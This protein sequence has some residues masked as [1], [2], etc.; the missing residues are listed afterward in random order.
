MEYVQLTLEDYTQSKEEIKKELGGIVKSFVRIGWQL[1]RINKTQAY[2]MDGYKSVTEMAKA[3]YGMTPDG[4]S[5]F[6]NVYEK[7]SVPGDTPQLQ[8][9]YRDYKFS[10]LTEMLKLSDDDQKL[11]QPETQRENIRELKRFNQE[12]EHNPEQLTSWKTETPDKLR[13]TIEEFFRQDKDLTN[14][15]FASEAYHTGNITAMVDMINPSGNRSFRKGTIFLMMYGEEKG[16]MVKDY[17][18]GTST[19]AWSEFAAITRDI[20]SESMD[21]SRIWQKHFDGGEDTENETEKKETEVKKPETET[22]KRTESEQQNTKDSDRKVEKC[23][24]KSAECDRE[25][26]KQREELPNITEQPEDAEKP[27]DEKIQIAPAQHQEQLTGQM[28]VEDYPEL[29][30]EPEQGEVVKKPFGTRKE[31]LDSISVY[32]MSL[33]MAASMEDCTIEEL[34]NQEFWEKWLSEKVNDRGEELK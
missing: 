4:V 18:K 19:I 15:L 7:Y 5:R 8:E 22:Q 20:F 2:Q 13:E 27:E 21:G 32:R 9:C 28:K 3:E 11:I 30:P 24:Q 12:N 34:G 6:M 16:V 17:L 26:L 14:R 25:D 29:M 31:Y 1:T 33:Y 23:D 10:Q